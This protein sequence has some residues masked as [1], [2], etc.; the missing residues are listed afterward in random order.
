MRKRIL[1][2][3]LLCTA[4]LFSGCAAPTLDQLYSLPRRS[5]AYSNMQ[6]AMDEAMAGMEFAAPVSGENQQ[7]VQQADLDGD[8]MAEYLLFARDQEDKV[9][10]VL[11]FRRTEDTFCLITS[12]D[13]PGISFEQVEYVNVDDRPG[14]EMVIGSRFSDQVL[15]IMSVYTF[16]ADGPVQLMT[17]NYSKFLVCDLDRNGQSEV[18][19]LVPGETDSDHGISV[20]YQFRNGTMERSREANLSGSVDAIKRIMISS[21]EGGE[22]AVYVASS[23]KENAIITDIFA[24]K[25]GRYTN[26]SLSLE[27]ETSVRTMRNYYVYAEDIDQD[28]VLELPSL[29][30]ME[31]LPDQSVVDRQY[32]IR[33]FSLDINCRETDKRYTYH[34]FNE[35]WYLELTGEMAQ[36]ISVQHTGNE[37]TFFL[38]DRDFEKADVLLR[39][40]ALSGPYREELAQEGELFLLHRGDGILYAAKLE[41][42]ALAQAITQQDMSQRFHLIHHDWKTGET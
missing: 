23:V 19:L 8:G 28:G 40:Y 29:I 14:M 13:F 1:F 34:N 33:W 41:N 2:L 5:E 20:C 11:I 6:T 4:L 27:S 7:T 24:L 39:I 3:A 26:I 22:P 10:K 18:V 21:L 36:R 38:W 32:L 37:F 15:G 35:G 9:P 16:S 17:S 42:A 30:T 25:M 12:I 31:A